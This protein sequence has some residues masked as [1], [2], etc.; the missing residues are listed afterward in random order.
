MF[1]V[2]PLLV[3]LSDDLGVTIGQAGQLVTFTAIPSAL[4]ALVIGPLSDRYGRRPTLIFGALLLGIASIG[5]ALAPSY[6]VL[7]ATRVLSGAGA[8][9]MAPA[10]FA[11]VA[12]LFPYYDRSRIYG[13]IL[14]ATTVASIGGIPAATILAAF[15]DWRWSFAAVGLVTL[16]A[17]P[18]LLRL[19]PAGSSG[20]RVASS[21]LQVPS[22]ES[23]A[24]LRTP[25]RNSELE[26]RNF[27]RAA[28]IPV[29]QT[30][31]ARALIASSFVM[32]VGSIPFQTFLGAF[33]IVRYGVTTADLAPI[34]GLGGIGVL[35]GSQLAGR[36]GNRLGQKRMM[37]GSVL[38]AAV[39]AMVELYTTTNVP[40]A[41]LVNFFVWLP[42]GMRFT[43][44]STIISEAVPSARGTMNALNAAFFNAGT[45]IGAFLGGVIVE[46]NGYE[47]LG[48]MMLAGAIISAALVVLFVVE[49]DAGKQELAEDQVARPR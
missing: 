41:T 35:I 30:P 4:L 28:Y 20:L 31:T 36:F 17:V 6:E 5:S 15:L 19:Y 39:L 14:G 23:G 43:S 16:S 26:T 45:V 12:D 48:P 8:A 21:E 33:F 7:A 47:P 2:G 9:A 25:T 44:A 24:Q 3:D 27:F 37:A 11:A 22:S 32:S 46:G 42:M 13:Y 10:V 49:V 40:V 29:L 1:V 34:L 18:P 38:V